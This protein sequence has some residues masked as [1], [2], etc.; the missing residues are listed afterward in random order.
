[1]KQKE[2]RPLEPLFTAAA[3]AAFGAGGGGG[4]AGTPPT[5]VG[6]TAESLPYGS[7]PTV[8]VID[9]G[10]NIYS[11]NVGIPEGKPGAD[12]AEGQQGIQGIPGRDGVD[13]ITPTIVGGTAESLPYGENPTV[14]ITE[15]G[16]NTYS[17]SVGIPAGKDGANGVD[18]APGKDGANGKDGVSPTLEI[19]TVTTLAAGEQATASVTQ[20]QGS[21]TYQLNFGIP[22]G[23]EG[24]AASST[25]S[26]IASKTDDYMDSN[27]VLSVKANATQVVNVQSGSLR[28][29]LS[30]QQQNTLLPKIQ[31][32]VFRGMEVQ[33]NDSTVIHKMDLILSRTS[34]DGLTYQ[35]HGV[36]TTWAASDTDPQILS[37]AATYTMSGGRGLLTFTMGV[38][39]PTSSNTYIWIKQNTMYDVEFYGYA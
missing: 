38:H 2:Y 4:G 28:L 36:F 9:E 39:N 17:V 23:P 33:N 5:M 15:T 31:T 7:E 8:S 6:G 30:T 12:G 13:G 27:I 10:E 35:G 18:G 24:T 37:V 11:V 26:L 32:V 25:F 19:G 16:E 3:E 14:S 21:D 22:Q 20:V 1:M 29:P 34:S